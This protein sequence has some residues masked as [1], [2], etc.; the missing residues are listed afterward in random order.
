MT[1]MTK[2]QLLLAALGVCLFLG[3]CKKENSGGG[4][5]ITGLRADQANPNDTTLH[6]VNPSQYVILDGA[7]LSSVQSVTFDGIAATIDIALAANNHFVVQV[8][9][10]PF[11]SLDTTKA[12]TIVVTTTHGSFTYHFPVVPPPPAVAAISNEFAHPGDVITL[13]GQFLYLIQSITFP[14]GIAAS[15][16]TSSPDG[17]SLTVTVPAGATTGGGITLVSTGGTSS[18]LPAAGFRDTTGMLC[19]FDDINTYSWGAT[20]IIDSPSF[21]GNN[22]YFAQLSYSSGINAGDEQWWNTGRSINLNNVQWVPVANMGDPITSYAM[23]FEVFVK[24]PWTVGGIYI[25]P[26]YTWTYLADFAP[27]KT[28]PANTYVNSGQWQTIVIPLTNFQTNNG[29]GSAA[30]SLSTLIGNNGFNAI[31]LMLVDDGTTPITNFDAGIDN[32]RVVKVQ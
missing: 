9:S 31:D 32:I 3:A 28:A 27:W 19:D 20:A 8:P 25:V 12:N 30:S 18:S 17:S 29:A 15:Q 22:G 6:Y 21:T 5:V 13:T 10:I 7:G 26:N 24:I 4:P 2:H 23:K 11:T 14:G 1:A 16:F